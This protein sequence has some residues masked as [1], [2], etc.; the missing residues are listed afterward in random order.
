M[1]DLVTHANSALDVVDTISPLPGTNKKTTSEDKKRKR[2]P[3]KKARAKRPREVA[4]NSSLASE[5][6][7]ADSVSTPIQKWQDKK[8]R[9]CEE[10]VAAVTCS[11]CFSSICVP[12]QKTISTKKKMPS[13]IDQLKRQSNIPVGADEPSSCPVC[14]TSPPSFFSREYNNTHT[15][16]LPPC[17]K[18]GTCDKCGETFQACQDDVKG[19]PNQAMQVL[20]R[21]MTQHRQHSCRA[22]VP[23]FGC[24]A[25]L[26]RQCTHPTHTGC[27]LIRGIWAELQDTETKLD[28][29]LSSQFID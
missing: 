8:C 4:S 13:L 29:L 1:A 18:V 5:A 3:D 24:P 17:I 22:S 23:L 2:G 26:I 27:Q 19:Y 28:T 16:P 15:N 6:S 11:T 7:S 10:N 20:E 25:Y 21:L 14:R 9:L 12:C